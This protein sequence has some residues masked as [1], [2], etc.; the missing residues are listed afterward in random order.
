MKYL[1]Y[2]PIILLFSCSSNEETQVTSEEPIEEVTQSNSEI[3]TESLDSVVASEPSLAG[4][5]QENYPN[6]ALKIEGETNAKGN[7]DGLW[8]SYYEDGTKWSESYYND[9]SK[10]GHTLS[11]FP[12]GQARY[13]GEYKNDLKTGTWKF[14]AEDGELIKEESFE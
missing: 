11:F 9:G 4:N 1:F 14:Y 2:F 7:R 12:N 13:V 6:G 10:E 8:I 5:Y 3:E